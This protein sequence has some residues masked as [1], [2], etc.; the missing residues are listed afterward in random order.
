MLNIKIYRA[1]YRYNKKTYFYEYQPREY[2]FLDILIGE[3]MNE[4]SW[5]YIWKYCF[6]SYDKCMKKCNYLNTKKLEE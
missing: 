1:Y 4:W 2:N 6:F 3:E 5:K